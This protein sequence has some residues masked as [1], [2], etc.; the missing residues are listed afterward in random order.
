MILWYCFYHRRLDVT[1]HSLSPAVSPFPATES[2]TNEN[3]RVVWSPSTSGRLRNWFQRWQVYSHRAAQQRSH[4]EQAALYH[5]QQLLKEAM[6]RWRAH[7]L[8]CVRKKTCS[9]PSVCSSKV[10][11]SWHR[12]SV[13][14]ASAS[15]GRSWQPGNKSSGVRPGPCGSGPS[16]YRQRYGLRGC[17][18]YLRGGGRRHGWNKP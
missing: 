4:L 9:L 14:P 18:S 16:H 17:A 13:V 5:R 15:G 7:H 10:P 2:L 1:S 6:A 8:G 12:D 11:N 3:L